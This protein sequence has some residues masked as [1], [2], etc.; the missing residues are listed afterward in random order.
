MINF[1]DY[2]ANE[3]ELSN[4][5]ILFDNIRHFKRLS[6]NEKKNRKIKFLNSSFSYYLFNS[7]IRRQIN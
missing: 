5:L 3:N 7:K 1:I 2:F 4:V 6:K